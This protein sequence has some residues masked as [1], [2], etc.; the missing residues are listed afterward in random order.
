MS[1]AA[2]AVSTM[3]RLGII[4]CFMTANV[5]NGVDA[6]EMARL[7][8]TVTGIPGIGFR[9]SCVIHDDRAGIC[10]SVDFRRGAGVFFGDGA[11]V[12]GWDGGV[13][14]RHRIDAVVICAA[15]DHRHDCEHEHQL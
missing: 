12:S 8:S 13:I 1:D 9:E 6:I 10:A 2:E 5:E 11:G 15:T 3:P 7:A 14:H 4:G